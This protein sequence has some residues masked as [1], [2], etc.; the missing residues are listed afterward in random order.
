MY[1]LV[2]GGGHMGT[3]LVS[4][5]IQEGHDVAV[6]DSDKRVTDRIF[7][8][9]GVVV[10]TGNATDLII[11]EQ[12]GIKRA[13]VAVAMTGRDSDN[14]SFCLLSRYFG[15]PRVLARMLN[16]HYEVPYRL[17]GA[18]KIHNEADILVSS[19]LTSIQYPEVGALMPL[20]K[21]ELVIAELR[22]PEGSGV[23]GQDIA[24]IV[25]DPSFPGHCV[26]IGVETDTDVQVADGRTVLAPGTSVILAAHKAELAQVIH[27][28]TGVP[29]EGPSPVQSAAMDSLRRVPFFAG[30]A[31]DDLAAVA[32]AATVEQRPKGDVIYR[33]GDRGDRLY[34][35][36]S[37]TVEVEGRDGRKIVLKPPAFFGERTALTG[38]PRSRTI[39]VVEEA[40]LSSVDG[41]AV[42]ALVLRNP[43]VAVEVAKLLAERPG[44]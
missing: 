23:A 12:A 44:P 21:G 10:H 32:A 11:L 5:L 1:V 28:L 14:L 7:A 34:V 22:I 9:L 26:F 24:T 29:A 36:R 33:R 19:F 27:R 30:L 8:E 37:G 18:T 31:A 2:A 3:H 43:F 39:T 4:R 20:A 6:I 17:V 38:H 16:P 40:E 41:A 15:V 13:D 35:L 42:R 25:R